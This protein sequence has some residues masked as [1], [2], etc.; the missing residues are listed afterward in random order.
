MSCTKYPDRTLAY[1]TTRYTGG[2]RQVIVEDRHFELGANETTTGSR[3]TYDAVGR[4]IRTERLNGLKIN[5]V[6][7]GGDICDTTL[8]S[9][10]DTLSATSTAYY[11]DG[12]VWKVTQENDPD[13]DNSADD[14]VT[15]YEYS[16]DLLTKITRPPNVLDGT[17]T[18]RS[19]IIETFDLNG[20][21]LTTQ[22]KSFK[23]GSPE[24]ALTFSCSQSVTHSTE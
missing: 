6:I 8:G 1:Q 19:D 11:E 18:I 20:N 3:T 13:P 4:V 5:A 10:A 14:A 17:D 2:L 24:V 16:E 12:R 7:S 15:T 23:I 22:T 21:R 9:A